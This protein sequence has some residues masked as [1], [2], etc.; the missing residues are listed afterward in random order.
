[1]ESHKRALAHIGPEPVL[2]MQSWP[3]LRC[4]W[5]DEQTRAYKDWMCWRLDT[6][7][8]NLVE[9]SIREE[10]ERKRSAAEQLA[11]IQPEFA[12]RAQACAEAAEAVAS[13]LEEALQ[14]YDEDG[15]SAE[16]RDEFAETCLRNFADSDA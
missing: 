8:A 2:D 4:R 11:L 10:L 12:R 6:D 7:H 9:R 3:T 5:T 15:A 13:M 14:H 1:M 16:E